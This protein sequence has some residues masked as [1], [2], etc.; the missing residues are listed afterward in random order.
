MTVV[1]GR[2]V[3]LSLKVAFL[4]AATLTLI[5]VMGIIYVMAFGI[6]WMLIWF[7]RISA[8]TQRR[9]KGAAAGISSFPPAARPMMKP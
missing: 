7:Y 9:R 6:A 5:I 2:I 8:V 1:A 4:E 3:W